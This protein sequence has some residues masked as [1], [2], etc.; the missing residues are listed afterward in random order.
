VS[1]VG[2][3]DLERMI[4]EAR[5]ARAAAYAPYSNY[6]VGAAVLTESGKIYRGMNMENASYGLSVCAE[7]NAVAQAILDGHRR[8]I[9][10]AVV[11][12]STP[13]A[14]PCGM[15]R[16]VLAEFSLDMPIVLVNEAGERRDLTLGEL[17]PHAFRPTDLD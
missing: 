1:R 2:D 14:A 4:E 8:L 6:Q 11:T 5:R 9:A 10:C 15:C 7:R 13:P 12:S 16:Q 17:L 3:I